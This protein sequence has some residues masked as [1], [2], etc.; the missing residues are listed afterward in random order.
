[1]LTEDEFVGPDRNQSS[2]RDVR[3]VPIADIGR[4]LR[5]GRFVSKTDINSPSSPAA[6]TL[7]RGRK[8]LVHSIGVTG[9]LCSGDRSWHDYSSFL[10]AFRFRAT[11][12]RARAGSK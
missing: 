11:V 7:I 6:N 1:S 2:G 4:M 12:P 10:T 9:S 5:D 3:F 8:I